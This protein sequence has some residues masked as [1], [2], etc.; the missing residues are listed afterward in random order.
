[1]KDLKTL[2]DHVSTYSLRVVSIGNFRSINSGIGEHFKN[3]SLIELA[4]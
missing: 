4:F 1:M 2:F 3:F